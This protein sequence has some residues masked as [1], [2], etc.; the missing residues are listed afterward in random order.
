M[1]HTNSIMAQE[2]INYMHNTK[3]RPVIIVWENIVSA[4]GVDTA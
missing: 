2:D 1:F 4:Y 3:E